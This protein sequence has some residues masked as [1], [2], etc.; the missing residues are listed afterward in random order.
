V[1]ATPAAI[2]AIT[3]C[4]R[5]WRG[6]DDLPAKAIAASEAAAAIRTSPTAQ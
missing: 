3:T 1:Y 6:R 2:A 4:K 5:L